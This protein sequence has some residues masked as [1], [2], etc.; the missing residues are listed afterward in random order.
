[1]KRTK[2]ELIQAFYK[3]L[4]TDDQVFLSEFRT[5]EDEELRINS[6]TNKNILDVIQEIQDR[7]Y[8]YIKK[9]GRNTILKLSS[10]GRDPK[11]RFVQ[12]NE[13][14]QY[15]Q[16]NYERLKKQSKEANKEEYG[17]ILERYHEVV[18]NTLAQLKRVRD[19]EDK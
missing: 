12:I 16:E 17:L 8:I 13:P 19:R 11:Q 7:P 6:P 2:I 4:K 14:I 15:L 18:L 10:H 5:L 9:R 3:Y 1:M